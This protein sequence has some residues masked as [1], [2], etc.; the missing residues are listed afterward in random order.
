[1]SVLIW[2][3]AGSH[4]PQIKPLRHLDVAFDGDV[5]EMETV[6]VRAGSHVV[7]AAQAFVGIYFHGGGN[8]GDGTER[9]GFAR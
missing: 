5:A 6:L 2:R 3:F 1:M 4:G 8:I 9:T 7:R